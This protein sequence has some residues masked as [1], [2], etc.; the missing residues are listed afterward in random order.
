MRLMEK[1]SQKKSISHRFFRKIGN[2]NAEIPD[3]YR[4]RQI[5]KLSMEA[6]QYITTLKMAGIPMQ[7]WHSDAMNWV[8]VR[9]GQKQDTDYHILFFPLCGIRRE[10]QIQFRETETSLIQP[11]V[12]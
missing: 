8:L 4:S 3:E 10:K 2:K 7:Y 1:E 11:P 12:P 5:A 9:W 6:V